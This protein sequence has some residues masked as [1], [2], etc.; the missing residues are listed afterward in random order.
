VADKPVDFARYYG[1]V[2]R[3]IVK[4]SAEAIVAEAEARELAAMMGGRVRQEPAV[5]IKAE[6]TCELL[7]GAPPGVEV[8]TA[9]QAKACGWIVPDLHKAQVYPLHIPEPEKVTLPKVVV[10]MRVRCLD[11]NFSGFG[12]EA[13]VRCV[14]DT[15]AIELTDSITWG[16]S[17]SGQWLKTVFPC[18]ASLLPP[19]VGMKV[20][21]VMTKDAKASFVEGEYVRH[22]ALGRPHE[23]TITDGHGFIASGQYAA[24][25]DGEWLVTLWPLGL[26]P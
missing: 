16:A 20:A 13:T 1:I 23:V 3:N 24:W 14:H 9:E 26:V 6:K 22:G 2:R 18:D 25:P 15:G 10:G 17:G 19:R 7:I 12:E 8:F 4:R 5:Q 21:G 11:V